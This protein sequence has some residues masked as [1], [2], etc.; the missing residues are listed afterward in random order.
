MVG[1][2][3]IDTGT[4]TGTRCRDKGGVIVTIMSAENNFTIIYSED[5]PVVFILHC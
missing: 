3:K 2:V 4:G 1:Y 5:I